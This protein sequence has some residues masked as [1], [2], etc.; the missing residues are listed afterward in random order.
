MSIPGSCS[1]ILHSLQ[2][3]PEAAK[4]QAF[5]I[6]SNTFYDKGIFTESN[7]YTIEGETHA[8][9]RSQK[10]QRFHRGFGC[11]HGILTERSRNGLGGEKNFT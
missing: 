11:L 6:Q 4:N 9:Q 1:D 8:A 3:Q 5:V 10:S 7:C 2:R